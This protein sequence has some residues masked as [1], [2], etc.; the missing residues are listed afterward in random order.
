MN[1]KKGFFGLVSSKPDPGAIPADAPPA[2]DERWPLIQ[3]LPLG[4]EPAP[5]GL[6]SAEK[7]A[8]KVPPEP[9][10]KAPAAE[11]GE[12]ALLAAS[13]RRTRNSQRQ[14]RRL[15]K[16]AVLPASPPQ[17]EPVEAPEPAPPRTATHPRG[18]A[19]AWS[20]D[21]QLQVGEAPPPED[22]PAPA[23]TSPEAAIEMPAVAEPLAPVETPAAQSLSSEPP[24]LRQVF[25]R[26]KPRI[27]EPAP[28]DPVTPAEAAPAPRTG[29]LSRLGK[30]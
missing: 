2:T 24:S 10:P 12:G 27:E 17:P 6:T 7:A 15:D 13:L 3:S 8:W 29:F 1:G 25:Q 20:A 19:R 11:P 16:D 9:E 26:L 30:R 14:A 18:S 22:A 28:V 23:M 4:R 21:W 5:A